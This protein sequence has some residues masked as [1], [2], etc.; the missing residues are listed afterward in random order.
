MREGDFWS[1]RPADFAESAAMSAD[2]RANASRGRIVARATRRSP[3][4]LGRACSESL[5]AIAGR[6][7][8]IRDDAVLG[9]SKV[10]DGPGW[11]KNVG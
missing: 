1:A 5:A 10:N 11:V 7:H 9:D 3:M 2:R 6:E 8:S 4:L